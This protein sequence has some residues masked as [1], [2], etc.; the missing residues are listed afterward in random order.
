L[1]GFNWD[2]LRATRELVQ[3]EEELVLARMVSIFTSV[4]ERARAL[5]A[6]IDPKAT[7]LFE[8]Q[9]VEAKGLMLNK[10]FTPQMEVD[11]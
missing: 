8:M 1:A 11:L 6:Q 10:V 2:T 7:E 9:R 3:A 5:V 4:M